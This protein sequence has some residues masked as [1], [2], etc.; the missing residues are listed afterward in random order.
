M[1]IDLAGKPI[2]ITGASSGIGKATALRCAQAGMPVVLAA[3]RMDKLR[4][5]ADEIERASGRALAVECDVVDPSACERMIRAC[6]DRFGSI[7]GVFANAGYGVER[8]V[9]EMPDREIRDMFEANFYGTL[10]TIRP[11]LGAMIAAKQGHVLMCSSCVARFPLP[12]FSVYSA[13][14][15][16][17]HHISRAMNLELRPMGVHVSSVHPVGTKTEFFDTA[18]K[19]SGDGPMLQHTPSAFMQS[20]DTVARAVV[21]CLRRPRPEVWTSLGVRVG[22]GIAGFMPRVTDF[23]LRGMVTRRMD[24]ARASGKTGPVTPAQAP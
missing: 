24:L 1:A 10:N 7:Y 19:L 5:V 21:S 4:A 15:A 11:A 14:K 6:L 3:R 9:H 12:Y 13:T 22:M 2:V 8:A 20:A 17:Q 23:T 18:A 16:A